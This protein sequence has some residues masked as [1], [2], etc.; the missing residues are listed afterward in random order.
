VRPC[1]PARLVTRREQARAREREC[2]RQRRMDGRDWAAWMLSGRGYRAGDIRNTRYQGI[3]ATLTLAIS[4]LRVGMRGCWL[5]GGES[6]SE[7]AG[8]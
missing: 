7:D 2:G 3:A 6:V 4:V 5:S 8:S 1:S